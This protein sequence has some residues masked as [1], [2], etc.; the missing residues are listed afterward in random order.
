MTKTEI[1]V[2][3]E[4]LTDL[5]CEAMDEV[6][7]QTGDQV[8]EM[9]AKVAVDLHDDDNHYWIEVKFSDLDGYMF[10]LDEIAGTSM[11]TD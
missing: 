1:E 2:W 9:I 10:F 4:K 3:E 7:R 5:I 11:D 8:R 6:V